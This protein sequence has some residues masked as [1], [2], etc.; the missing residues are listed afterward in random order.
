[1]LSN[2]DTIN[3]L[4]DLGLTCS[5]AKAYL[6]L[7]ALKKAEAKKVAK[8]SGIARQDIYRIMPELERIGI[9]EKLM[10]TPIIYRAIPINEGSRKLL[11]K[12]TSLCSTLQE[13]VKHLESQPDI[14]EEEEESEEVNQFV[15]TSERSLLQKK[16]DD[17][18]A[19]TKLNVKAILTTDDIKIMLFNYSNTFKA[20]VERG[21]KISIITE[22]SSFK[23]TKN[24]QILCKNP[25]F[26]I[27]YVET[28]IPY[29]FLIFDNKEA[30]IKISETMVPSLWTNNPTV[31][32]LAKTSFETLWITTVT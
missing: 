4:I 18:I 9:V 24:Q 29:V 7:T 22:K 14:D 21:V 1:M 11:E 15:L 13:K 17:K 8:I 12:K 16:I 19:G 30:I 31:I 3:L 28:T 2:D 5:Q 23:L 27:R 6:A 26:E 10:A 32:K 25:L 20:A